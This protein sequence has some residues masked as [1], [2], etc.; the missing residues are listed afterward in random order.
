MR[1]ALFYMKKQVFYILASLILCACSTYEP[2]TLAFSYERK[3]P[4]MYMFTAQSVGYD[5]YK[6]DYGDGAYSFGMDGIHSFDEPGQYTVTLIASYNGVKCDERKTINVTYPD[7]Y[8]SGYTLYRIPYN[9]RY[10]KL[11]VKDDALFPSAWD[12]ETTYTPMLDESD[13]PYTVYFNNP[14]MIENM[15]NHDYYTVQ[16]IRTNNAAN[17]NNDVSCMKQKLTVKELK[18]YRPEY[19][20]QTETGSTT[21]GVIMGYRY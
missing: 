20:L 1:V 7:V 13:L 14:V 16:V 9:D 18:Q 8:V 4:L 2:D 5:E 17:D 12:W 6:W 15:L 10:Y 3:T 19:I 21:V 11:V